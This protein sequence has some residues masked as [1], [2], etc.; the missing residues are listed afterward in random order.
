MFCEINNFPFVILLRSYYLYCDGNL[1]MAWENIIL[2]L[3]VVEEDKEKKKPIKGSL[4]STLM[5]LYNLTCVVAA[6]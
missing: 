2:Q 3:G 4:L 1:H 5:K 6:A